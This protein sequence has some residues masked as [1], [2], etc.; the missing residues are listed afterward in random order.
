ME[1]HYT[2]MEQKVLQMIANG[3][4]LHGLAREI[5]IDL[6]IEGRMPKN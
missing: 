3:E 2:K 6:Q 5:A 1:K 4:K